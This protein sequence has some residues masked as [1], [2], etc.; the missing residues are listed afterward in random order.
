MSKKATKAKETDDVIIFRAAEK[1]TKEQF[2]LVSDMIRSEEAKSGKK[3]I[4][5]PASCELGGDE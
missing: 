3:I 1:M 5:M 4:L 2:E